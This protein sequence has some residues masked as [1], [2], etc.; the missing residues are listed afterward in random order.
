MDVADITTIASYILNG[1]SPNINKANADANLDGYIDVA[2]ITTTADFILNGNDSPNV[3]PYNGHKYV[4]LG[5]PSRLKWAECN[6][7]A[8]SPEEYG[9]YYA[10]GETNTKTEYLVSNYLYC[11]DGKY[12]D[13][14]TNISETQYDAAR[15]N[16]GNVW[17]MPT[18]ND[19]DELISKCDWE[20]TTMNGIK[21]FKVTSQTNCNYIFLPAAGKFEDE[22]FGLNNFGSY[23]SG[24]Y[25]T[26]HS[27][28]AYYLE[29]TTSSIAAWFLGERIC[30]RTIR[31]VCR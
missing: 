21:G 6:I 5:L 22:I 14:G 15:A 25:D 3:D 11:S 26:T 24:Y 1:D 7:G 19:F 28:S 9:N 13:L 20:W 10:W 18:K 8:D 27:D 17:R 29:L 4:D 30:G 31:P 16:W 12:V 23:W 2:D